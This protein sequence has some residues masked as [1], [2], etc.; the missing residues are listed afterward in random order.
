MRISAIEEGI[1][2]ARQSHPWPERP[3]ETFPARAGSWF[4]LCPFFRLEDSMWRR[5]CIIAAGIAL[6]LG[7]QSMPQATDVNPCELLKFEKLSSSISQGYL[8]GTPGS[9]PWRL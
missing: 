3:A 4:T 5:P 8:N 1:G 2:C 9:L 6:R 7:R